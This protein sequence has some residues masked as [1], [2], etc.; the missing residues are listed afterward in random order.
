MIL[1]INAFQ[2]NYQENFVFMI[3]KQ[4]LYR[5]NKIIQLSYVCYYFNPIIVED[6]LANE[7]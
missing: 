4:E 6:G 3:S 1:K 2:K 7:Y 5:E